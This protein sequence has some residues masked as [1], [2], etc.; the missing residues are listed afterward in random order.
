MVEAQTASV[1]PAP[2]FAAPPTAVTPAVGIFPRTY[3]PG[4]SFKDCPDCPDMVVVPAGSFDMGSPNNESRRDSDEGPVH[5]VAISRP[6]AV[7]KFE[8]TQKEWRVVMGGNPS[9]FIADRNPVDSVSWNDAREFVR[10]LSVKTGAKYRLL[11]E[12]EWEYVTRAGSRTAFSTGER[13]TPEQANFSSSSYLDK[14]KY[15]GQTLPVGQFPSNSFGLFDI[16]GNVWEWVEDCYHDVYR[17]APSDGRAW[18]SGGDCSLRI[19]RGGS[20]FSYPWHT[21]SAVRSKFDPNRPDI[22]NGLRVARDLD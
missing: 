3:K 8:V 7:G 17:D 14:S 18:I 12:A 20:W 1:R 2:P 9:H 21:R 5:Q 4:D 10:K 22:N 15:R 6:F 16:H 13:I 19:R 11:S